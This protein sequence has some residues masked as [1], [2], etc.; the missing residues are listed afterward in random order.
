MKPVPIAEFLEIYHKTGI[1]VDGRLASIKSS[2]RSFEYACLKYVQYV[3]E[4]PGFEKFGNE[5]QMAVL[6]GMI[7]PFKI[8]LY[9]FND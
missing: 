2:Y 6:K 7:I 5:D 1:D 9:Y 8:L 3:Q 4:L